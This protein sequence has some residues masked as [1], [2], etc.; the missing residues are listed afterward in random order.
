M[1]TMSTTTTFS[2]PVAEL[3]INDSRPIQM[4][5]LTDPVPADTPEQL[6]ISVPEPEHIMNSWS[7]LVQARRMTDFCLMLR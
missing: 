3:E 6:N 7:V 4:S 1:S 5:T 2:L